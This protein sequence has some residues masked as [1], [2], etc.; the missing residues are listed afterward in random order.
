[1]NW[2]IVLLGGL[3]YYVT[4]FIGSFVTGQVI[5]EGILDAP[6]RA[7]SE[8]WRPELVQ[9]PPDMAALMPMWMF[10]G[11]IGAL[12]VAAI[13]SWIRPAFAGPAW[14]KGLSYGIVLSAFAATINL[15]WSG[16]FDLPGEIW[17]WWVIEMTLLFVIGC[18]VL[19][20]VAE[21][22]APAQ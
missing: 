7:T 1:M 2:K 9:D 12:V 5:H 8:F 19:A 17:F 3:A 14:K 6:Y 15:G 18:T 4:I 10:N 16:V 13:F 22:I 11:L 21:K 20:I